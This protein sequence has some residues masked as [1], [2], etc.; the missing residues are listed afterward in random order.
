MLKFQCKLKNANSFKAFTYEQIN[1]IIRQVY[2]FTNYQKKPTPC[3]IS[4]N[5][6]EIKKAVLSRK[7]RRKGG[8]RADKADSGSGGGGRTNPQKEHS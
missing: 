8:N 6:D 2:H 1:H 3:V 5:C 7:R 4:D